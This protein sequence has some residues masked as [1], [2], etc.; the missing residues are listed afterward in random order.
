M[1][2]EGVGLCVCYE[3]MHFWPEVSTVRLKMEKTFD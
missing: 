2:S 1:F 3:E